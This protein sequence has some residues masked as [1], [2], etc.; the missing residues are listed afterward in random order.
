[1]VQV[2]AT[3][4]GIA[5]Q[6]TLVLPLLPELPHLLDTSADNASWLVTATLLA[7]A[8]RLRSPPA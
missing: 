3:G 6:Q 4:T 7:G 8:S 2:L 1:V 5:L